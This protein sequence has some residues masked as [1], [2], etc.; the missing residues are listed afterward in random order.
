MPG[1]RDNQ[2]LRKWSRT[3][4]LRTGAHSHGHTQDLELIDDRRCC[5]VFPGIGY[6]SKVT[7]PRAARQTWLRAV[8]TVS[9]QP[10]VKVEYSEE[11]DQALVD[12]A[13]R[14]DTKV[15]AKIYDRLIG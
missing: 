11:E 10:V 5:L 8:P 13:A 3:A 4:N 9:P 14:G 15:A 12:A 7:V 2:A 6:H 1:S